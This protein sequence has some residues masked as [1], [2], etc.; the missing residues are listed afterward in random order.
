MCELLLEYKA[1]PNLMNAKDHAPIHLAA[2]GDHSEVVALLSER[3]SKRKIHNLCGKSPLISCL[4]NDNCNYD[5]LE[6]LLKEGWDPNHCLGENRLKY[7][8]RFAK[9]ALGKCSVVSKPSKRTNVKLLY[10]LP[11]VTMTKIVQNFCCS[12]VQ[13]STWIR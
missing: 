2:Y 9:I 13:K 6:V 12:T 11:F 1:D 10:F 3:T 5:S 8:Q 7:K 4:E